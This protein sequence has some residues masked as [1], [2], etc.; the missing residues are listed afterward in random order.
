VLFA[1]N[2]DRDPNEAQFLDWQ[3]RRE[4]VQG[5]TLRCSWRE[6]PQVERT[7]A[8][9]LS[10]PHWMWG[11]EMG[12]NEWGVTIG[13]EAIFAREAPEPDGLLGMDLLRL[14]LERAADAEAAVD[15]IVGLLAKH[16]QGGRCSVER[17]GFS[18]HNSYL[19]AD[20]SGAFV[21]ETVG[22][23][24]AV[25]TVRGARTISNAL[26]IPSFAAAHR[27]ALRERRS[28]SR[29]RLA[30]TTQTAA[31]ADTPAAMM[32]LLRDHGAGRGWP[33]YGAVNGGM[34]GPCV[35][36][37]GLLVS[38]QTVGSWVAELGTDRPRHWA[39]ATA[40]PCLSLFKPVDVATPVDAGP[41]PSLRADAESLWWRHERLQRRVMR[42][43]VQLASAIVRER[44]AIE[45]D[46][47]E[48]P[49]RP[50]QAFKE[51]NAALARWE[52]ATPESRDRRPLWARRS[53]ERRD[54]GAGLL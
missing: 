3:P 32:A 47:L 39:T 20:P 46:W 8:V 1:K 37:G 15:V 28:G 49:P 51:A 22:R 45:R 44:D 30:C 5:T 38:S 27:A 6:I 9:L 40:A 25:E 29:R 23:D 12:T 24:W 48:C 53:C 10:R 54:R 43:P 4:H 17:P 31:R 13:N 35:H 52:L 34:S 42:D 16:G 50:E 11:A 41:R 2:S 7:W 18:Y 36:P 21:L 14:A 33:R 26:T 19:V